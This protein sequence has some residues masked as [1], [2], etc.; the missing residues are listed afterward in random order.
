MGHI[1]VVNII[2]V[3]GLHMFFLYFNDLIQVVYYQSQCK[4]T[5]IGY[6]NPFN[7]RLCHRVFTRELIGVQAPFDFYVYQPC[8]PRQGFCV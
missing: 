5:K 8:L 2:I 4:S 1:L 7:F 3:C 6:L